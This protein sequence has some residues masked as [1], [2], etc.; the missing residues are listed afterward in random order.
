MGPNG[1]GKTT[2]LNLLLGL[3]TPVCSMCVWYMYGDVFIVGLVTHHLLVMVVPLSLT[4]WWRLGIFFTSQLQGC[5]YKAAH[6]SVL[7]D[8]G[9]KFT[10]LAIKQFCCKWVTHCPLGG[11]ALQIVLHRYLDQ[12]SEKPCIDSFFVYRYRIGAMMKKAA[13]TDIMYVFRNTMLVMF[14]N[15]SS[16]LF[17][18]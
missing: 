14:T 9:L 5:T 2:L 15:V 18:H 3:V 4:V 10:Y 1:V 11:P 17:L 16:C 7:D 8:R 12:L 13:D 6:T